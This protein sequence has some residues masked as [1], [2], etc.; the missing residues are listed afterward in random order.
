VNGRNGFAEPQKAVLAAMH[1]DERRR[2]KFAG[3]ANASKFRRQ[4]RHREQ[5]IGGGAKDDFPL[6]DI[7]LGDAHPGMRRRFFRAARLAASRVGARSHVP[8]IRAGRLGCVVA[9]KNTSPAPC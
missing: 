6:N 7:L 8:A 3:S 2:A 4:L 9:A 5:V 1:N